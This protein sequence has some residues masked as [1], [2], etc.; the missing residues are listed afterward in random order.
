MTSLS[1]LKR[2]QDFTVVPCTSSPFITV[3][4]AV[5]P[6]VS[7]ESYR[8]LSVNTQ[9]HPRYKIQ[10]LN[11]RQRLY[12]WFYICLLVA[13]GLRSDLNARL[14]GHVC[15]C[16]ICKITRTLEKWWGSTHKKVIYRLVHLNYWHDAT[17]ST[18]TYTSLFLTTMLCWWS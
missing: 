14:L 12:F 18:M 7:N 2:Y 3:P 17:Q 5:S 9:H 4:S 11:A 8:W 15:T 10:E 6:S 13:A 1:L 16:S